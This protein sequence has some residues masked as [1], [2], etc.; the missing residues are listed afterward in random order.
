MKK[1]ALLINPIA[2]MGGKVGL[3]GTDGAETLHLALERGAKPES[4]LKT[5]ST[6]EKLLP[7]KEELLFLTAANDLGEKMLSSFGFQYDIIYEAKGPST[8]SKDTQIFLHLLETFKPDLLLFAGG[9]GTARDIV[10]GLSLD[11]PVIG[12][13]TGVK[14]H[15]A[16]FALSP[17]EAGR[18]ALTFLQEAPTEVVAREVVDIDEEAFRQDH[19][20]TK[21]YGFLNVPAANNYLQ[22]LKSPTPQ[23]ENAA[24]ISA[25]LQ[26]IDDMEKDTFYIIGSGSSASQVLKELRLPFTMLGI[27]MIKNKKLIA[28]DVNEQELL[29][30]IGNAPTRLVVSP[31]GNQGYVFGRGNQQLSAQVLEKISKSD[32]IILSTDWKL[33]SLNNRA[34]LIYTGDAEID[35]RFSGFYRVITGYEQFSMVKMRALTE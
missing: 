12:I 14:I 13:P 19:I 23:S 17:A 22:S 30:I 21:V 25:A 26:V 6:L 35:A 5:V 3:K 20:A 34:M 4:A 1:V 11:V 8:T 10:N 9:D 18:L 27:D 31:M 7:L 29:K 32:L 15:S 28:K 16:V 24:Q 33:R 2:G